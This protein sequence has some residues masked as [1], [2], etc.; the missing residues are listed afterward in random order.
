MRLNI[1]NNNLHMRLLVSLSQRTIVLMPRG[2]VLVCGF[3]CHYR[4]VVATLVSSTFV[5]SLF[6][7]CF[8]AFCC[9][10]KQHKMLTVTACQCQQAPHAH[11]HCRRRPWWRPMTAKSPTHYNAT[12]GKKKTKKTWNTYARTPH[13]TRH[14]ILSIFLSTA[15][16]HISFVRLFILYN[17]CAL[18]CVARQKLC[19]VASKSHKRSTLT[20]TNRR[21]A[22]SL[23]S[24]SGTQSVASAT[25]FRTRCCTSWNWIWI[26][27]RRHTEHGQSQC[28]L[29]SLKR[30]LVAGGF[31]WRSSLVG[32]LVN[33]LL[34]AGEFVVLRV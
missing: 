5:L 25:S 13:T 1:C 6:V 7:V 27:W 30:S 33:F 17:I 16:K 15:S 4:F 23:H 21:L 2:V 26:C 18:A 28:Y 31:R 10:S 14:L 34:R 3:Y 11:S 9:L 8:C 20:H 22:S 19:Y 29:A 12:K 32:T 24:A